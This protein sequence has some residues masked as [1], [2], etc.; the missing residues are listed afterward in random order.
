MSRCCLQ[1]LKLQAK[2]EEK[3]AANEALNP[4]NSPLMRRGS[5]GGPAL[6]AANLRRLQ[7]RQ[8]KQAKADLKTAMQLASA[9][10][11]AA[12]GAGGA[13]AE[14]GGP[15]RRP[16][17]YP[18][19]GPPA[20]AAS[21]MP[22]DGNVYESLPDGAP[23]TKKP[24]G[25]RKGAAAAAAAAAAD[26]A[27]LSAFP[28]SFPA[29]PLA[30]LTA[31]QQMMLAQHTIFQNMTPEAMMQLQTQVMMAQAAAQ[32]AQAT[33]AAQGGIAAP[34][35]PQM[36]GGDDVPPAAAA[37]SS[38]A[39]AASSSSA[40]AAL[41]ASSSDPT[42]DELKE[43]IIAGQL[44]ASLLNS[45]LGPDDDDSDDD[46]APSATAGAGAPGGPGDDLILCQFEK[47]SHAKD[48][49]KVVLRD[50]IVKINKRDFVFSR[51]TG[52]F[53]W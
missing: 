47:V 33:Q 12:A 7:K 32:A 40:A 36:D 3:L 39:A 42:E 43:Q 5:V 30:P 44:P 53:E 13:D 22:S 4:E 6:P 29:L 18:S 20:A 2:W 10:Q 16:L 28:A 11:A 31:E 48:T 21:S 14:A 8:E 37:A 19:L 25:P 1:V 35:L 26:A 17:S 24:R 34:I 41:A 50:G 27:A 46:A 23:A 38:S 49:W 45:V 52:E 9:Q 51:A 15:K